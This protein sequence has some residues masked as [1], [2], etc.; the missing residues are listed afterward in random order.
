[1]NDY[2]ILPIIFVMLLLFFFN[3]MIIDSKFHKSEI[4]FDRECHKSE[5]RN[6]DLKYKMERIERQL[7]RIEERNR[8]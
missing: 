1:M 6:I 2:L 8:K 4:N 3:F 5:M 7:E